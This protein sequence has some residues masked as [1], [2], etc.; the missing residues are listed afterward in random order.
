M[1]IHS[2]LLIAAA[3]A[4]LPS[5]S[6]ATVYTTQ[7]NF[8]AANP[9]LTITT[10]ATNQRVQSLPNPYTQGPITFSSS[11]NS[12]T[13]AG[14]FAGNPTAAFFN[15][16]FAS[17]VALSFSLLNAFGLSVAAGYAGAA[18]TLDIVLAN[19]GTSVFTTSQ[20]FGGG[21]APTFIGFN[22]L[23]LF[24]SVTIKTTS[25]SEFILIDRI[26]SGSTRTVP[27][28][29]TVALLGLGLL[30]FAASRRKSTK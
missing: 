10:F 1:K 19:S 7:A 22:G 8:D 18:G 23:G 26:E 30:G 17:P 3:Y 27:E 12:L 4:F 24:D 6:Q 21:D 15:D 9:G 11:N 29:T 2:L 28:P 13:A 20:V 25:N 16:A 14:A 5:V